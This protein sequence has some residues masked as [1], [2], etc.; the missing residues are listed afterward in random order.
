MGSRTFL[1]FVAVISGNGGN[2][3]LTDIFENNCFFI[4]VLFCLF[5]VGMVN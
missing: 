3:Q 1:S 2:P 4:A 5:L